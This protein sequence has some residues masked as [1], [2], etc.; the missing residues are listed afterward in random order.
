MET[1]LK[2]IAKRLEE[3]HAGNLDQIMV[4]FNNHRSGSFFRNYYTEKSRN[5]GK[6]FYYPKILGI[7]DLV[8]QLGGLEI[9]PNELLLFELFDIH[10]ELD[11]PDRKYE[12]FEDFISFGEMMLNDFSEV[13]LYMVDAKALFLNLFEQ[14]RLG[15]WDIDEPSLNPMQKKYLSFYKSLY[16]YYDKL[17]ARLMEKRRAFSGMAYRY[18]AENI[19]KLADTLK[20]EHIYFVGFN[21]LSECER[22]IINTFSRR[23]KGSMIT[24]GDPYYYDDPNQEAG[25]FLRKHKD[26]STEKKEYKSHFEEEKVVKIVSCPEN[27]LQT[28]YAGEILNNMLQAKDNHNVLEST[29]IVLADETLLPAMLN[30]LPEGVNAANIT[31]GMAYIYS[32]IHALVAKLF[33]LYARSRQTRFYHTDILEVLSDNIVGK[34]LKT[35]GVRSKIKDYQI[36]K[37]AIT[38]DAAELRTMA[39]AEEI[40]LESVSYLFEKGELGVDEFLAILERLTEDLKQADVLAETPKESESLNCLSELVQYFKELQAQYHYITSLNTLQ[41]IYSRLAS[42]R[43]I[44]FKGNPMAG[45]QILGVLETRNLDFEKVIMLSVNEGLLPSGKKDNTLIP[46]SLKREFRLPTYIEKDAVYAYH[47]FRFL[48]RAKDIYLIYSTDASG[49]GKGERSRF[50]MQLKDELAE[51]YPEHINV[52]EITVTVENKTVESPFISEVQKEE[53]MMKRLSEIAEKGFSPSAINTYLDCPLNF[54][55]QKIARIDNDEELSDEMDD[56]ELGT[57]IHKILEDIYRPTIGK[58]LEKAYLKEVLGEYESLVDKYFEETIWKGESHEGKNYFLNAVA[59]I[60]IK[61]RLEKDLSLL[62][63]GKSLTIKMVE[64]NM[65]ASLENAVKIQ[66]TTDRVDCIDGKETRVVDYKTGNVDEKKELQVVGLTNGLEKIPGKWFQL[67]TYAWLY[68]KENGTT[69][70]TSGIMPL[71]KLNQDFLKAMTDGKDYFEGK[72]FENIEQL[73]TQITTEIMDK[74]IPFRANPK[75]NSCIYCPLVESCQPDAKKKK[76]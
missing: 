73:L 31:M 45:L 33:S 49:M 9:I 53:W 70:V 25:Y 48:Q 71:R 7:D 36:Q 24:D 3:K 43:N 60:Q 15:E 68:Q 54:Y 17:H 50:I 1:F 32:D 76:F 42:R 44:S 13:D 21:A 20:C 62:E 29:S 10:R 67:A 65:E 39:E 56:S 52:E 11:A 55:Y 46:M 16:D 66:G 47:F 59:K 72:D 22:K 69:S 74:D 14:K 27:V 57:C 51:R 34:L 5:E 18:V 40:N 41:K 6:S 64:Q 58:P 37:H 61:N 26:D 30:S 75:S 38:M 12:N 28:K 35:R 19:D 4:V 63:S 23:G 8:S 2:E